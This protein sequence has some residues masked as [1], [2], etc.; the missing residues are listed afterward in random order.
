MVE[1]HKKKLVPVLKYHKKKFGHFLKYQDTST[2]KTLLNNK[3]IVFFTYIAEAALKTTE[4]W[5]RP[6]ISCKHKNKHT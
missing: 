6:V 1:L 4:N 5:T 3:K 2:K